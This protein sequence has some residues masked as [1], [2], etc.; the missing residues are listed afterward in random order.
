MKS[1]VGTRIAR[2]YEM[3]SDLSLSTTAMTWSYFEEPNSLNIENIGD[4]VWVKIR[5]PG[6]TFSSTIF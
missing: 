3:W 5:S 1:I 2:G 4:G 6:Y